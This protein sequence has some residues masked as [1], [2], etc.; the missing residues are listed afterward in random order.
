MKFT[1]YF[2]LTTLVVVFVNSVFPFWAAMICIAL[3]TGV[4]RPSKWGGI[5]G[6]GL[7]MGVAWLGQ[8]LFIGTMTSSTLPDKMGEVMGLGAGSGYILLGI[9]GLLGVIV[10]AGSAWVGVAFR[11]MLYIKPTEIY[12]GR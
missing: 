4:F 11:A 8:L 1:L 6:G 3:L 5:G 2:L 12:L 7:A 9:T 10:G